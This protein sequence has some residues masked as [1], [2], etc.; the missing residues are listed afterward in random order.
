MLLVVV[1]PVE[2][3]RCVLNV[4]P[5]AVVLDHALRVVEHVVGIHDNH[6]VTLDDALLE[7]VVKQA[8][9]LQVPSLVGHEVCEACDFVLGRDAAT[10][11]GRDGAT[12]MADEECVGESL[13]DG[14]RKHSW[15]AGLIT[16]AE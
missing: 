15:I 9:Q 7:Q 16:T 11:V 4:C 2:H 1:V 14:E 3:V 5:L 6:L 12:G 13:E 10:P 8:A